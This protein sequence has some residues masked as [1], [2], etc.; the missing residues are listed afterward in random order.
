MSPPELKNQKVV[1]SFN[2]SRRSLEALRNAAAGNLRSA[3]AELDLLLQ[4]V[5]LPQDAD[6]SSVAESW[7]NP[8]NA[9]ALPA[10]TGA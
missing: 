8:S 4:N 10:K 2:V 3:S 9:T 1:C 5:Y 7:Q 6:S